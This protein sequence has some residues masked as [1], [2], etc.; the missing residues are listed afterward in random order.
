MKIVKKVFAL[1]TSVVLGL[2]FCAGTAFASRI[3][4]Q[5]PKIPVNHEPV[6]AY[7][8]HKLRRTSEMDYYG[9]RALDAI[10]ENSRSVPV[11]FEDKMLQGLEDEEIKPI[12]FV[13]LVLKLNSNG[14]AMV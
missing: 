9:I 8:Y 11:S 10:R 4:K 13:S 7:T 1:S 3:S 12:D 2:S 6:K 14:R 5:D